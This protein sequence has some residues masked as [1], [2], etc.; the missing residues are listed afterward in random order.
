MS[1][2]TKKINNLDVG[3]DL[4]AKILMELFKFVF[5]VVIDKF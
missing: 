5:N 2:R 1:K 4:V 3:D